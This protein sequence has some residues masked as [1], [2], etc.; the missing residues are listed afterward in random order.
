MSE[1]PLYPHKLRSLK[2]TRATAAERKGNNVNGFKDFRTENGS[3]EGQNLALTD[4]FVP[5]L[6]DNGP[7]E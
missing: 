2:H 7:A 1:V 6:L 3:S 4:S 5:S